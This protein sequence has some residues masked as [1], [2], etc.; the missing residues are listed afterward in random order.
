MAGRVGLFCETR[1]PAEVRL[2]CETW[3]PAE[4]GLFCETWWPAEVRLFFHFHSLNSTSD[5]SA[6]AMMPCQLF[7]E[8]FMFAWSWH[9][10]TLSFWG[11]SWVENVSL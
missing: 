7:L 9:G 1:W 4:V 10:R 8:S 2:F 6:V 11:K 5:A 3:Y